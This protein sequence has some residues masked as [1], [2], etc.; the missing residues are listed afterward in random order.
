MK[1]SASLLLAATGKTRGDSPPDG[2]CAYV[3]IDAE[4][5]LKNLDSHRYYEYAGLNRHG[6]P[7][8]QSV[9]ECG[10]EMESGR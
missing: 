8:Y 5:N 7:Y 9:T 4:S 6:A 2:C 3:T 10:A 1:L